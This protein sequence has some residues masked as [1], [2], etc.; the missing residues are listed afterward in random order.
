[1][2]R[3][4]IMFPYRN[5]SLDETITN[6]TVV[7]NGVSYKINIDDWG[8]LQM[9]SR[10]DPTETTFRVDLPVANPNKVMK[11]MM[12]IPFKGASIEKPL[13][14]TLVESGV[15]KDMEEWIGNDHAMTNQVLIAAHYLDIKQVVDLCCAVIGMEVKNSMGNTLTPNKIQALDFLKHECSN[16]NRDL[17]TEIV[18]Y[19]IPSIYKLVSISDNILLERCLSVLP[20]SKVKDWVEAEWP[21]YVEDCEELEFGAYLYNPFTGLNLNEDPEAVRWII[22][23]RLAMSL[24]E[25]ASNPCEEAVDF[26]LHAMETNDWFTLYQ[27]QEEDHMEILCGNRNPRALAYLFEKTE[28]FYHTDFKYEDGPCQYNHTY[29]NYSALVKN[30]AE[31]VS[32]HLIDERMVKH[33]KKECCLRED[34]TMVNFLIQYP[35]LI[36][37]EAFYRN[38]NPIAIQFNIKRNYCDL[39]LHRIKRNDMYSITQVQNTDIIRSLIKTTQL[40]SGDSYE[41]NIEYN[42]H[43]LAMNPHDDAVDYVLSLSDNLL[44]NLFPWLSKNEHPNA[45][46]RSINMVLKNQYHMDY[47]YMF[48]NT[49]PDVIA[50]CLRNNDVEKNKFFYKKWDQF[51]QNK[52]PLVNALV[53]KHTEDV[54]YFFEESNLIYYKDA[55]EHK[56]QV[57]EWIAD[58]L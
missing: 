35:L 28:R 55:N 47:S 22:D 14:N 24:A 9:M 44:T 17:L 16:L 15:T 39:P 29:I 32:R 52:N 20:F 33:Y 10:H 34:D 31:C 42:F 4:T 46:N 37:W 13:K 48:C 40:V 11:K 51:I 57:Q 1:M 58:L 45:S 49:N 36:V 19:A 5:M 25:F 21:L 3:R 27:G 7:V 30:P 53:M 6:V 18:E 56:Q 38:N 8:L 23:H 43:T 54:H 26:T 12:S 50:F 41:Y 2:K